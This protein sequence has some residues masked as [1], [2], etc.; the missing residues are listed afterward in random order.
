MRNKIFFW[1][2]LAGSRAIN[3]YFQKTV[4]ICLKETM[5]IIH[6]ISEEH[7]NPVFGL[8][9]EFIPQ[10]LIFISIVNN[11]YHNFYYRVVLINRRI[12]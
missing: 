3:Y 7:K 4:G 5:R 6:V 12:S 10:T 11:F 1:L 9:N 8:L 2:R